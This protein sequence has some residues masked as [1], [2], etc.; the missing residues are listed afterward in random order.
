MSQQSPQHS[1]VYVYKYTGLVLDIT[2]ATQPP[3][4]IAH[5]TQIHNHR[6][7]V[8]QSVGCVLLLR[9]NTPNTD[10]S[11]ALQGWG[12]GTTGFL[13]VC[14]WRERKCLICIDLQ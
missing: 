5:H 11:T 8:F 13:P 1:D 10:H 4:L 7:Q 12:L 9:A 6:C 14:R 2:S 3:A